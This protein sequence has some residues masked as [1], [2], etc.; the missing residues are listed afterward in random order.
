MRRR[1]R[2]GLIVHWIR[3]QGLVTLEWRVRCKTSF[4]KLLRRSV[5]IGT[6]GT[7]GRYQTSQTTGGT[8]TGWSKSYCWNI[9]WLGWFLKSIHLGKICFQTT[10]P[11]QNKSTYLVRIRSKKSRLSYSHVS[12]YFL[13]WNPLYTW[14]V[15]NVKIEILLVNF[16]SGL[17]LYWEDKIPHSLKVYCD[18][19]WV[20]TCA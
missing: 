13:L 9:E 12:F 16:S 19:C 7:E 3:Q 2:D 17:R 4:N 8:F 11:L 15:K 5:V 20:Q 10:T 14:G 1:R 18:L 6:E